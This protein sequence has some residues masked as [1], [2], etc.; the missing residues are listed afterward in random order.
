MYSALELLKLV[1]ALYQIYI[2]IVI[3]F[4]LRFYIY[5]RPPISS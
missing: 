3:V 5:Y 4:V 2:V 1:L